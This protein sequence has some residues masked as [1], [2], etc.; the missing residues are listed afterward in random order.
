MLL[1]HVFI[2]NIGIWNNKLYKH[3]TRPFCCLSEG[4]TSWPWW[5]QS[6]FFFTIY[7]I[8]WGG[9]AGRQRQGG[10]ELGSRGWGGGLEWGEGAAVGWEGRGGAQEGAFRQTC[11]QKA[12]LLCLHCKNKWWVEGNER[13]LLLTIRVCPRSIFYSVQYVRWPRNEM[14]PAIRHLLS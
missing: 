5:S 2:N 11:S 8:G 13:L 14:N 10:V 7:D 4:Q 6:K 12:V 1:V 3:I 9:G